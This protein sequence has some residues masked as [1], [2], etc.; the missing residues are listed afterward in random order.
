[1]PFGM[2]RLRKLSK[3]V[4]KNAQKMTNQVKV[5]G[6]PPQMFVWRTSASGELFIL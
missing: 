3:L 6:T 4:T 1:M 5:A 2:S